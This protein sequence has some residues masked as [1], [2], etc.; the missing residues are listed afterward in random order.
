MNITKRAANVSASTTLAITATA[1][2]LKKRGVDVVAFSAGE[3]DFNTPQYIIDEAIVALNKGFTKYTAS[4]G[5]VELRTQICSKLLNDNNL[6]YKPNQIMVSNGAKQSLFNILQV[7]V[8]EGVEVVIPSPYWLTYPELVNICGGTCIY[9]EA[10]ASNKL[11]ITPKQL[12]QAL[13][14]KTRVFMFNS[15]SNPSGVVY[16]KREIE[17]LAEVLKDFPDVYVI[18]DE[19][20][21]KL[22]YDGSKHFSIAQVNED[23]F[24][25]T[26]VINGLS[27]SHA[28]TGWRIGYAACGNADIIEYMDNLQSHETSNANSIA[29]YASV[30]ALKG[31]KEFLSEMVST[32]KSR[33]D[34]LNSLLKEIKD[35]S[36][37]E[38]EG[39]FYTMVN[40]S[41]L[42][43]RK[44]KGVVIDSAATVAQ[45][46]ISDYAVA[47]IPCEAFGSDKYIRLTYTLAMD[48]II[49]GVARIS[50]FVNQIDK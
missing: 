26:I 20:Y 3:P 47:V 36:I 21:E 41:G 31:G 4:R 17:A 12:R 46:L 49:E 15:P 2:E 43:G 34:K 5:T 38:G 27:K 10:S 13:T 22:I 9:I 32:F 35:I 45:I 16:S 28:M 42:F 40:I 39:A 33:R 6:S 14:S 30:A 44:Y 11:K 7:L 37:I 48:K 18:S 50:K 24:N 29:Q 19:I 23:M 8:E 25:R 1:N